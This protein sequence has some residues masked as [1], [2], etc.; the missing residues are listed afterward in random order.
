MYGSSLNGCIQFIYI[1]FF[2]SS[3]MEP[4]HSVQFDGISFEETE[5]GKNFCH[6]VHNS[7]TK[8]IQNSVIYIRIYWWL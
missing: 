8:H 3:P 7:Q 2:F 5:Q 1:F 4:P 6:C